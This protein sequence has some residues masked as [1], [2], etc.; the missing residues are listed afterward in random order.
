MILFIIIFKI[1]SS[2]YFSACMDSAYATLAT[3]QRFC[4][5]PYFAGIVA[6]F[7]LPLLPVYVAFVACLCSICCL[8]RPQ[9]VPTWE[10]KSPSYCPISV[11]S[12]AKMHRFFSLNAS[13]IA[14]KALP[15]DSKTLPSKAKTLPEKP[16]K[17]ARFLTFL[18][19]TDVFSPSC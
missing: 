11:T 5:S 15:L 9:N 18:A 10:S 2:R 3:R 17:R 1:L 8:P 14:M 19:K 4:A 12:S 16:P 6:C 13:F 7:V